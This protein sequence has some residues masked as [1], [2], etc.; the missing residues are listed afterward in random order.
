MTSVPAKGPHADSANSA[1][2]LIKSHSSNHDARYNDLARWNSS[3]LCRDATMPRDS[4]VGL[5]ETI[6]ASARIS[7]SRSYQPASDR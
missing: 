2:R 3:G 4:L 5:I 6:T 7:F 1:S